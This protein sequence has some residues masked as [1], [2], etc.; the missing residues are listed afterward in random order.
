MANGGPFIQPYTQ[1]QTI[2]KILV[3]ASYDPAAAATIAGVL[4]VNSQL[5][6]S[7]GITPTTNPT[8]D[9]RV[10]NILLTYF[11]QETIGA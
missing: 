6:G 2:E 7:R 9:A 3:I 8:I 4:G 1:E 10:R 5:L 11:S